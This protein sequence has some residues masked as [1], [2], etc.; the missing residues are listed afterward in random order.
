MPPWFTHTGV[1]PVQLLLAHGSPLLTQR[2]LTLQVCPVG[3]EVLVHSQEPLVELQ[4]SPVL[5]VTPEQRSPL[6]VWVVVLQ[7]P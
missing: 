6:Q 3:Q 2:L 1:V 7:V 5:Q 4:L